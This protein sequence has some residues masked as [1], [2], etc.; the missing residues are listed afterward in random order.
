MVLFYQ[1]VAFGADE[2]PKN[3]TEAVNYLITTLSNEQKLKLV[4]TPSYGL[5]EFH[6]SI[7][8]GTRNLFGLHGSNKEL[9]KDIGWENMNADE[10]SEAI[11]Y[12]LWARLR[13]E[14]LSNELKNL[15]RMDEALNHIIVQPFNLVPTPVL[16]VPHN[17]TSIS[18]AIS[19]VNKAIKRQEEYG[20]QIVLDRSV[21]PNHSFYYSE[22]KSISL[23]LFLLRMEMR[24][25]VQ[26]IYNETKIIITKF[27][28]ESNSF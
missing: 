27:V 12:A 14:L 21:N 4:Q 25:R 7:G 24:G 16:S 1:T 11:L 22:K 13:S 8:M 10:A 3:V 20:V 6:Y 18:A 15:E 28:P 17:K 23:Y 9:L 26:H 19:H 2:M 5:S